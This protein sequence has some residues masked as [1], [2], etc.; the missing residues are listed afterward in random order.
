MG[1]PLADLLRAHLAL[2]VVA[3]V[4][5]LLI[6]VPVCVNPLGTPGLPRKSI[7]AEPDA[8]SRSSRVPG[9]TALHVAAASG[10]SLVLSLLRSGVDPMAVMVRLPPSAI[11]LVECTIPPRANPT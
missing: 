11:K 7:T 8:G 3:T 1:H 2:A 9:A 6:Y 4:P 5:T 10:S